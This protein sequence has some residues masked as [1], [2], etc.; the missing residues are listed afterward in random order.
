MIPYSGSTRE[1]AD[2]NLDRNK[3]II[4]VENWGTS[5]EDTHF[6]HFGDTGSNDD[7]NTYHYDSRQIFYNIGDMEE[8]VS[9]SRDADGINIYTANIDFTN[10]DTFSGRLIV[11]QG[12]GYTYKTYAGTGSGVNGAP[13]DGRPMGRT[14]YFSASADGT[15]YYPSNHYV[16]TGTSKQSIEKLTYKGSLCGETI[17]IVDENNDGK[18]INTIHVSEDPL[19]LTKFPATHYY[20]HPNIPGRDS[21]LVSASSY[22]VEVLDVGGADTDNVLKVIRNTE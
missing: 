10:T 15:I 1:I 17:S 19:H 21:H 16:N 22:C 18:F 2:F 12:K 13:V 11:D 8:A 6:I 20:G 7:Y 14:A 3:H 9:S 5:S 4:N